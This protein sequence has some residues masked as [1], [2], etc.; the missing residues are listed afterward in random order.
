MDVLC[1]EIAMIVQLFL[2]L[3]LSVVSPNWFLISC[4]SGVTDGSQN[5]EHIHSTLS[6]MRLTSRLRSTEVNALY[7]LKSKDNHLHSMA[8]LS[9]FSP[10]LTLCQIVI[11]TRIY[12]MVIMYW[13][14]ALSK[15]GSSSYYPEILVPLI[16]TKR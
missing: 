4:A 1:P 11:S 14:T 5:L 10:S 6:V 9:C 16:M 13:T 12:H 15:I 3:I 2:S 8:A 7:L